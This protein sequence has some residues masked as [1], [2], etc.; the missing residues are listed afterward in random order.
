MKYNVLK[1][2]QI[3]ISCFLESFKTIEF[4]VLRLQ[5]CSQR[6]ALLCLDAYNNGFAIQRARILWFVVS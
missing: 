6:P 3:E 4:I 1:K 2:V 5:G